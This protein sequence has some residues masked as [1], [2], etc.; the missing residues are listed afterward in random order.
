MDGK[1][2]IRP[3]ERISDSTGSLIS[4]PSQFADAMKTILAYRRP[5]KNT[6]ARKRS[7]TS[8]AAKRDNA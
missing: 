3:D 2:M 7:A 4:L 8:W 1:Q 6:S 5:K